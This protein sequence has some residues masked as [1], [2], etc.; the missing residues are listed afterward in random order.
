MI[1]LYG[2]TY[3]KPGQPTDGHNGTYRIASDGVRLISLDGAQRVF[4]RHDG[5]GPVT[6]YQQ[7]GNRRWFYMFATSEHDREWLGMPDSYS[8]QVEG[9]ASVINQLDRGSK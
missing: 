7:H 4:I 6:V 9:A 8:E 1:T 2:K 5:L 3:V